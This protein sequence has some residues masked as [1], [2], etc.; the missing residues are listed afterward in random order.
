MAWSMGTSNFWT[1][2]SDSPGLLR[3]FAAASPSAFNT[4]SFPAAVACS[5][6][7]ESPVRQ[8]TA[9]RPSTYWFPRLAIEPSS[10][11]VGEETCCAM[12][13]VRWQTSRAI[14]GVSRTSGGRP[15]MR[16]VC[17]I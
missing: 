5:S 16:S 7:R 17:W 12:L 1:V 10:T 11:A 9:F 6:A 13:P 4:C 8:F 3:S 15:I 14:S 2:L